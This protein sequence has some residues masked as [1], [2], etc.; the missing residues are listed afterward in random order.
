MSHYHLSIILPTLVSIIGMIATAVT[1]IYSIKQ[2]TW[3]IK[4]DAR[5]QALKELCLFIAT[6]MHDPTSK[7]W[8][9][10]ASEFW[11]VRLWLNSQQAAEIKRR[12]GEYDPKIS[13]PKSGGEYETGENL[14]E[15][16]T[17]DII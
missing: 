17:K 4:R 3:V 5:A 13:P 11:R 14:F 2:Q 1:A 9:P 10:M 15:I 7:N 8:E 16:L 12:I 6:W